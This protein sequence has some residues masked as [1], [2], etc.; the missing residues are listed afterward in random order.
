MIYKINGV[1]SMRSMENGLK[2]SLLPNQSIMCLVMEIITVMKL[3]YR[4]YQIF[5]QQS[6]RLGLSPLHVLGK[7]GP[8]ACLSLAEPSEMPET[9]KRHHCRLPTGG[10]PRTVGSLEW[11]EARSYTAGPAGLELSALSQSERMGYEHRG[12]KNPTDTANIFL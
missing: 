5:T 4:L 8:C 12:R 2:L 9:A 3:S 7:L 1:K 10:A 11:A 6:V